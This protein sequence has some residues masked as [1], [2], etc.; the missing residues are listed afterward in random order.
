MALG[1][2]DYAT[3]VLGEGYTEPLGINFVP[4]TL[5]LMVLK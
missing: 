3:S 2:T 4:D 5:D 1:W